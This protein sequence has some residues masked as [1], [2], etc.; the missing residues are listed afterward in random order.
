VYTFAS[1]SYQVSNDKIRYKDQN[2][3]SYNVRYGYKTLFA[4]T[5]TNTNKL[6][7]VMKDL[8]KMSLFPFKLAIS[9]MQRFPKTKLKK[10]CISS[11]FGKHKLT[12]AEK[13]D[14]I[15]EDKSIYFNALKTEIDYRL[16]GRMD[17]IP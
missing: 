17:G 3:I 15:I 2:S 14:I 8:N 16:V 7:L 12:F 11:L 10:M 9:L 1:Q 13:N 6:R 4:Y 5:I